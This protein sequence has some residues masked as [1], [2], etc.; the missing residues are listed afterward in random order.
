MNQRS[1]GIF[2]GAALIVAGFF[3]GWFGIDADGIRFSVNGWQIAEIA[4]EHGFWYLLLYLLPVGAVV[5][6]IAAI[7]DHQRGAKIAA[8]VGGAFLLWAFVEVARLLWRTTFI[9]LWLTVAGA[10]VLCI[11]GL[12]ALKTSR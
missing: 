11:G 2:L 6:C 12:A 10:I 5:A 1:T 7:K 4:R 9:G 3:F 8:G